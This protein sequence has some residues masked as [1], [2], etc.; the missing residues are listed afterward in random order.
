MHCAECTFSHVKVT[1]LL[2]S[3]HVILRLPTYHR[4]LNPTEV[5][6]SQLKEYVA[7]HETTYKLPDIKQLIEKAVNET[8]AHKWR[9][10]MQCIIKKKDKLW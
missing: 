5:I 3:R 7:P 8:M 9:F 1:L 6:W 4:V 2:N 10:S